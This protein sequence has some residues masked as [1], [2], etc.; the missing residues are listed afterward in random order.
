M[1]VNL[2][3]NRKGLNSKQHGATIV[4]FSIVAAVVFLVL[5][6]IMEVAR[7]MF[8]WNTLNEASR[9]AARLATVCRVEEVNSGIVSLAVINQMNGLLP[10]FTST[11]LAFNY[12]TDSG[13]DAIPPHTAD[14]VR[15][16]IVNY[17][18]EMI[19][20]LSVDLSRFSPDFSTTLRTESMGRTKPTASNPDGNIICT[21]TGGA[22]I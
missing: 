11:N 16:R 4:E 17:R 12:L 3:R 8:T 20:P 7:L 14:Y 18:Y 9:R 15:A 19:L 13:T 2:V 10:G 21:D 1:M 5:F 22:G 6:G